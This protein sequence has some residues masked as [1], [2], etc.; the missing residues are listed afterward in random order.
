MNVNKLTFYFDIARTWAEAEDE[1][2]TGE[3]CG[4]GWSWCWWRGSLPGILVR[5]AENSFRSKQGFLSPHK[6]Q[7]TLS[8]PKCSFTCRWFSKT[9][10]FRW[11]N[12]RE[13]KLDFIIVFLF[14][15]LTMKE[16]C[17]GMALGV[18]ISAS[19]KIIVFWDV[20]LHSLADSSSVL[21]EPTT[22]ILRVKE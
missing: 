17:C 20:L 8:K 22:S 13:G 18:L 10:L 6:R 19:V 5:A 4:D 11:T 2:A 7:S 12:F 3:C 16:I 1:G 15:M 21:V 9:L 14:V